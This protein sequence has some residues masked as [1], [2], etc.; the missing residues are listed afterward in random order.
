MVKLET[1]KKR[2]AFERLFDEGTRIYGRKA[3]A[4]AICSQNCNNIEKILTYA[5]LV[6]KK[7]SRKAVVR[8]RIKRLMRE[9]IRHVVLKAG[10][11]A[12]PSVIAFSWKEKG[13]EHP[14]MISFQDVYPEIESLFFRVV[15]LCEKNE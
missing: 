15:R 12:M 11:R 9:S 1:L 10:N 3:Y 14:A 7:N 8:N 13:I 5:V 4:V 6:Q 2:K